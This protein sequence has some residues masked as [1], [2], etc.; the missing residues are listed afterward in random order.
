MPWMP[1][2]NPAKL[3]SGPGST[4]LLVCRIHPDFLSVYFLY[5]YLTLYEG[6]THDS[7]EDAVTSLRLYKKH[8]ELK[9]ENRFQEAVS[10]MYDLG[11][12]LNWKVPESWFNQQFTIKETCSSPQ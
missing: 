9:K 7:V 10:R 4:T 11:K 8:L 1:I 12:E 2:A 6:T 5:E 3:W